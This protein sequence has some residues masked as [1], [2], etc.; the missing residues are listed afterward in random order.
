MSDPV[1][2]LIFKMQSDPVYPLLLERIVRAR[3]IIP[4]YNHSDDNTADWKHNS[5]IKIGYELAL[6]QFNIKLEN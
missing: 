5:E 3:P 4:G 6:L 1:K 2:E